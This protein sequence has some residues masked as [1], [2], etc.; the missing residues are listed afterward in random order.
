MNL[1]KP[2]SLKIGDTIGILA[3]SGSIE[4]D[5]KP[6]LTAIDYFEN[7]GY[8]VVLS[9]NIYSEYRYMAGNDEKRAEELHK[10]FL[11][12][13]IKAIICLRGGFGAIRLI[14]KI[15]YSII[16]NNPKIFCGFS[17]VTALS[18]MIYKR[19]GLITYSGPMVMSDFGRS[20]KAPYA[21][22]E[23]FKAVMKDTYNFKGTYAYKEGKAEGVLWGGN[24]STVVSLCGQDFI[25][26]EPFI[27]F[28]EDL[29]EPVYKIDKMFTQLI[30]IEQ[31]SQNIKG[32]AVGD[33]L[34]VD[35]KEW[36]NELFQEVSE[37]LNIPVVDGFR[38]S[39]LR[40]KCTI[41]IGAS[42]ELEGLNL[43]IKTKIL[44]N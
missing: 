44:K 11:N 43:H 33:F 6:I 37:K 42:A 29:N 16:K 3:T 34:G 15:D 26:D 10:F 32:L 36:L 22:T 7:L 5:S 1:I 9:E 31:F 12:S 14:N 17:D 38:F 19:T 30:N 2:E 18:L 20:L 23:F 39:H 35:N 27:F 8:N 41:P 25:P 13:K 40:R 28:A 4:K 24:L 21:M